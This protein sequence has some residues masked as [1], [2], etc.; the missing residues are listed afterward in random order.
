[1]KI[2]WIT[3]D[4]CLEACMPAEIFDSTDGFDS[5]TYETTYCGEKR[6]SPDMPRT[7]RKVRW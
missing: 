7:M 2:C 1:M 4:S 3:S 6:D 5:H